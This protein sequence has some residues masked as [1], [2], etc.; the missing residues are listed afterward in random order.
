MW[1]GFLGLCSVAREG[2]F[3][4][5]VVG[6]SVLTGEGNGW[7]MCAFRGSSTTVHRSDSPQSLKSQ[8]VYM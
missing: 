4:R 6:G 7:W 8:Q 3:S 5:A 2:I 1:S